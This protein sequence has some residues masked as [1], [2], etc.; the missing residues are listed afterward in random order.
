MQN[1]YISLCDFFAIATPKYN[2][3]L[4][5]GNLTALKPAQKELSAELSEA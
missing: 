5:T 4:P 3:Y 2:M 1:L